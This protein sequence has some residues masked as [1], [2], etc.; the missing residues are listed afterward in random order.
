[1]QIFVRDTPPPL[2]RRGFPL[3]IA[4]SAILGHARRGSYRPRSAPRALSEREQI[5]SGIMIAVERQSAITTHPP[6]CQREKFKKLSAL[7]AGLGGIG[8]G[9][10]HNRSSSICC[11]GE[12]LLS[13]VSPARIQDALRE[14]VITNHIRNS[15]VLQGEV[16]VMYHQGVH[17]FVQKILAAVREAL[18]V[19]LNGLDGL[20]PILSELGAARHPPLQDP[21]ALLFLPIPTWVFDLLAIARSNQTMQTHI[22]ADFGIRRGQ[23]LR[24]DFTREAGIPSVRLAHHPQRFDLTFERAMP[25]HGEA[26]NAGHA[27]TP[28][29]EFEAIAQFF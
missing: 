19:F 1:M 10:C 2:K 23:R 24:L 18:M 16:I 9:D 3:G 7:R 26:T 20:A 6:L 25:P 4:G 13:E 5:Q 8:W 17:Q 21:Q 15:Q 28:T 14:M 22:Q 29:V 11:F 12:Q 27:Q